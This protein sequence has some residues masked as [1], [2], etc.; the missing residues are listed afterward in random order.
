[1]AAFKHT[2]ATSYDRADETT[3]PLLK[4]IL[5]VLKLNKI[6]PLINHQNKMIHTHVLACK[7]CLTK[8]TIICVQFNLYYE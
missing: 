8:H 6:S 2:A 3:N 4:S 5:F 7:T 1:M